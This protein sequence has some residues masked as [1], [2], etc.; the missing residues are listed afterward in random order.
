[1]AEVCAHVVVRQIRRPQ[2]VV[3]FEYLPE[4]RDVAVEHC[5]NSYERVTRVVIGE[6]P[7]IPGLDV[8][9]ELLDDARSQ[10]RNQRLGIE[11]GKHH[12]HRP[13]QEVGIDEVGAD[14]CVAP[15]ARSNCSLAAPSLAS[16]RPHG[17]MAP[18]LRHPW[19]RSVRTVAT[20]AGRH[21]T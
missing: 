21:Y 14:R 11:S 16:L 15:S 7:L 6:E 17:H 3:R 10:L 19:L 1:V 12:A 2:D 5:G 9:V 18:S 13:E 20:V 8:V 4:V